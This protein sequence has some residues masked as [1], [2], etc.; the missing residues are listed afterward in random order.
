MIIIAPIL[1]LMSSVNVAV[2]AGPRDNYKNEMECRWNSARYQD[3]K[4]YKRKICVQ[5]TGFIQEIGYNYGPSD[6]IG[7]LNKSTKYCSEN[8]CNIYEWREEENDLILYTCKGSS[9]NKNNLECSGSSDREVIGIGRS[10]RYYKAET[11]YGHSGEV[12]VANYMLRTIWDDE[13]YS[14]RFFNILDYGYP[15]VG[16]WVDRDVIELKRDKTFIAST[17]CDEAGDWMDS[18]GKWVKSN[19]RKFILTFDAYTDDLGTHTDV[20]T[21]EHLDH[22]GFKIK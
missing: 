1:L 14:R 20:L 15:R 7:L 16:G 10:S 2:D 19:N 9:M 11:L 3:S 12:E 8:D 22:Y 4:N 21:L 18:H 17:C 13:N 6:R 5:P